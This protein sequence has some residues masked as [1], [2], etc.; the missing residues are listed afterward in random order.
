M[1]NFNNLLLAGAALWS[2]ASA[3]S[4]DVSD[5]RKLDL[6]HDNLNNNT[7]LDCYREQECKDIRT[8]EC[9][10]G[11]TN[12]GFSRDSCQGPDFAN[13]ICCSTRT[14]NRFGVDQ[15][16]NKKKCMWRGTG[17]NCNGAG[18]PGEVV[19]FK[20]GNGGGPSEFGEV[21]DKQCSTGYKYFTCPLPEWEGLTSTC[22]WTDCQGH[23]DADET[24]VA[25][26]NDMY[27]RCPHQG[28]RRGLRYC[29]KNARKPLS[30]CHWVG[31]G[32]CDDNTCS[33]DEVTAARNLVGDHLSC[34]YGREKS[35]CCTPEMEA[36]E[37][38]EPPANPT[39]TNVNQS[40]ETSTSIAIVK[41]SDYFS[42]IDVDKLAADMSGDF[43]GIDFDFDNFDV[44]NFPD[45]GDQNYQ[46]HAPDQMP[47]NFTLTEAGDLPA[48]LGN[49]SGEPSAFWDPF[50][51]Q[52]PLAETSH[53]TDMF[54]ASYM[55]GLES[56]G[57]GIAH[58]GANGLS[59]AGNS[60]P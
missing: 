6:H 49:I 25:H 28:V 13:P 57:C 43:P 60:D 45:A 20:S 40:D 41:M 38:V 21:D 1:R 56:V 39:P 4:L 11:Y 52:A 35:L 15:D 8:Y 18:A 58:V 36:L 50:S 34:K 19:L 12:V 27:G 51:L 37:P 42:F 9:K 7:R 32:H 14:T 59:H 55:D 48:E 23:C 5:I 53:T 10:T 16:G 30:N 47:G 3:S 2:S 24:E 29:C 54:N 26:A 33:P 31:Q 44:T 46:N 22:R 17:P